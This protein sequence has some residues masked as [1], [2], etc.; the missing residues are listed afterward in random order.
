MPRGQTREGQARLRVRRTSVPG[1]S[2]SA[3]PSGGQTL[4]WRNNEDTG[5]PLILLPTCSLLP[6][7]AFFPHLFPIFGSQTGPTLWF[8]RQR[9]LGSEKSDVLRFTQQASGNT[10]AR[11]SLFHCSV[12]RLLS[13]FSPHAISTPPLNKRLSV[14][15]NPVR[16]RHPSS[17]GLGR[18]ALS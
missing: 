9:N 3:L 14:L 10:R 17:I 11:T 6:T 13:P 1:G 4:V 8:G 18:G 2:S 16:G 15:L 12:Q 7:T 5:R